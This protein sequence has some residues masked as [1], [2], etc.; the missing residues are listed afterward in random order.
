MGGLGA[1][2]CALKKPKFYKSVSAFA[3]IANM[4][5]TE[6]GKKALEGYF[7]SV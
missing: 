3:P 6:W 5:E 7:G 1:L 4:S 2:N